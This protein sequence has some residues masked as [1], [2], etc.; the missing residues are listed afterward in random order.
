MTLTS[1][2]VPHIINTCPFCVDL[3]SVTFN[4]W[5]IFVLFVDN[6]LF[7]MSPNSTVEVQ[8]SVPKCKKAV[9]CL[10]RKFMR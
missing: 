10:H 5:G 4:V 6:S 2:F 8:T 9:M 7:K 1:C 3:F